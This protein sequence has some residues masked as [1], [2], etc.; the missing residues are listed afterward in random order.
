MKTSLKNRFVKA[1]NMNDSEYYNSLIEELNAV[2]EEELNKP[3]EEINAKVIDDCCL[4]IQ[5]IYELQ[6]DEGEEK[7][8]VIN[9]NNVIKKYKLNQR[10]KMFVSYTCAAMAFIAIGVAGFAVDNGEVVGNN[11]FKTALTRLEAFVKNK[12]LTQQC[13]TEPIET[14]VP[15]ISFSDVSV[16]ESNLINGNESNA[17][18]KSDIKNISVILPPGIMTVYN[19][20]E[21]INLNNAFVRV[22]YTNGD[23]KTVSIKNCTVVKGKPGVNGK[24]QITVS[25]KGYETFIYVTVLTEEEKNPNIVTSVYGAFENEYTVEDMHVFAVF[26]DGTE[27]EIAKSECVISTEQYSDEIEKGVIVTVEYQGCSFQFFSE[28]EEV[29]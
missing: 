28:T 26:S 20:I 29:L 27:K 14:T 5:S 7:T 19:S 24:T 21:E 9:I 15:Q 10:R 8:N 25:Y 4:A 12:E 16:P 2:I 18:P 6:N 22:D 1:E 11:S 13:T 3:Y 23:K 17:E